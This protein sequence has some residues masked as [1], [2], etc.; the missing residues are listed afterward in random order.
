MVTPVAPAPAVGLLR[1]LPARHLLAL[2][3]MMMMTADTQSAPTPHVLPTCARV[4][5]LVAAVA[6]AGL[7]LA[8]SDDLTLA[9]KAALFDADIVERFMLPPGQVATRRRLP[10]PGRPY[11]T[12]NMPDN[13]YMTGIYCAAQTWRYLSSGTAAASRLA[14]E[15]CTALAHLTAVSGKPGLLARASAPIGAPWFD[16]GVWRESPDG[17]HRW[18]GDVS[19]DQVDGLMFGI[20]VYVTHLADIDRRAQL[21]DAVRAIVDAV[22]GNDLRIIGFDGEPT[23]WGHYEPAYVMN[24]EPMNALLL[25]QMVKVAHAVTGDARYDREYRRFIELGYARL[26]ER[27]RPDEPPLDAN[28]S[29]DVLIALALFPLLELE[30]DPSIRA[31]YLEAARRWFRGGAHPGIDAEA[32]PFASFLWS[33]WSGDAGDTAAGI[34]TLRNLPL[35]MKWNADTIA[36]YEARF[37]F[38]FDAEPVRQMAAGV[39]PLPI[40]QRGRTWSFL[41]HNPYVV[42]GDRESRAPF[43]TNG[44][45]FLVSYWFGRAHGMIGPDE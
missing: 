6:A 20:F 13:A 23:R 30:R 15:A 3:L 25:L 38:T 36:A 1:V 16:D 8:A 32:N 17:R 26:G 34:G 5:T 39:R 11:V 24:D 45:D 33:H 37:E 21:A 44:L 35:D 9:R 2:L 41:V 28:H 18:R 4:A 27:A 12:H 10:A 19:S 14:G 40:G 7:T 42:G 29:D 43:E 31:H 22:L